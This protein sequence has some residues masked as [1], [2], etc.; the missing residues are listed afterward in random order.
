ML[1]ENMWNEFVFNAHITLKLRLLSCSAI[2]FSN[3][4]CRSTTAR[5]VYNCALVQWCLWMIAVWGGYYT[6]TCQN[7]KLP[8]L[9]TLSFFKEGRYLLHG[10]FS[11]HSLQMAVI[12]TTF[13]VYV[14]R[15][16]VKFQSINN[17]AAFEIKK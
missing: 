14:L 9:S 1:G 6:M 12:F 13:I 4:L 11:R 8:T 2:F 3:R 5:F 16:T 7:T 15:V 17:C 10:P